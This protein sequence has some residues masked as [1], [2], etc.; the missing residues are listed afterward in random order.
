FHAFPRTLVASRPGSELG[1]VQRH[2]REVDARAV[3]EEISAVDPELTESEAQRVVGIQYFVFPVHERDLDVEQVLRRMQI[4]ELLG[5]PFLGNCDSAVLEVSR[6]ECLAR[7][8]SVA[9][10]VPL[11][12]AAQRLLS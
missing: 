1:V 3:Q 5:H 11:A 7:T 2:G 9:V 12:L 4:P 10:A 6:L 8:Y